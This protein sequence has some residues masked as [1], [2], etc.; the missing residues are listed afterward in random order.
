MKLK[1][2]SKILA[3]GCLLACGPTAPKDYELNLINGKLATAQEF[4]SALVYLASDGSRCS[5]VKVSKRQIL[6][7]AHCVVEPSGLV[8]DALSVPRAKLEIS[9]FPRRV[10]TDTSLWHSGRIAKIDLP[11]AYLDFLA[12]CYTEANGDTA[13]EQA[14]SGRYNAPEDLAVITFVQDLP[15]AWGIASLDLNPVKEGEPVTMV[16]YGCE[17]NIDTKS[18]I[19]RKMYGSTNV[20]SWKTVSTDL[21]LGLKALAGQ[22][23]ERTGFITGGP[24]YPGLQSDLFPGLCPGDSGGPVY[25]QPSGAVVGLNKWVEV[26]PARQSVFQVHSRLSSSTKAEIEQFLRD[27]LPESTFIKR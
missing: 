8:K 12:I 11:D 25:R 18:N 16:G 21:K 5:G 26:G 9:N 10:V 27:K 20:K 6:T 13:A 7:A 2:Q 15:T 19:V 22:D 24:E 3:L 14:C 17:K 4:T 1:S 23:I